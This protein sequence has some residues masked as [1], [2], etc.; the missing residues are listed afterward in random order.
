MLAINSTK[1]A[2][3][4]MDEINQQKTDRLVPVLD[5]INPIRSTG[6]MRPW[7]TGKPHEPFPKCHINFCV[8]DFTTWE[9]HAAR[10]IDDC[11]HVAAWVKNDHLDFSVFYTFEGVTRRYRPDF[12][13]RLADGRM[14][15]VE[16]KGRPELPENKAKQRY[17]D[18]WTRAV[19]AHGGFGT[20]AADQCPDEDAIHDV[21]EKHGMAN[22]H[23][24]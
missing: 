12:I 19:N 22:A 8:Y 5:P 18:E 14:L 7:G 13:I 1:I 4:V 20:W 17:L 10:T 9:A 11:K 24:H 21:L 23:V 6:D 15:L 3:H 2:Q 16:V